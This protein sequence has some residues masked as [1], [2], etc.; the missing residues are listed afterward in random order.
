MGG[1]LFYAGF[2]SFPDVPRPNSQE[3]NP[4][5]VVTHAL[6]Q[7]ATVDEVIDLLTKKGQPALTK[8]SLVQPQP[9]TGSFLTALVKPS[10]LS[11]I[12]SK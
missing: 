3:L 1:Q 10:S 4:G 11:L 8:H 7:C 2:A 6:L 9:F 12:T 5:Y